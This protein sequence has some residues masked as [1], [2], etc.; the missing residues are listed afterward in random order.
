[1]RVAVRVKM[2]YGFSFHD[3]SKGPASGVVTTWLGSSLLQM[4]YEHQYT[5]EQTGN[6]QNASTG[7]KKITKAAYKQSRLEETS[8]C[9]KIKRHWRIAMAQI[10]SCV[11]LSMRHLTSVKQLSEVGVLLCVDV[12]LLRDSL[13]WLEKAQIILHK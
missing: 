4:K 2:I 10:S 1:M 6:G 8:I 9:S 13:V 5:L 7:E 3:S 11:H 12:H